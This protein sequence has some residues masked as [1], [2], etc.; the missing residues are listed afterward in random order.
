MM[1]EE[2]RGTGVKGNLT[3]LRERIAEAAR[4][5]GKDPDRIQQVLVT[6]EVPPERIREAYECGERKFGENRVQDFLDK[7]A[8]L[9]RD[10]EW[11]FVGHLQTN[12][13]KALLGKV[14]LI[15]SLDSLHLAREVDRRASG[16]G[17]VADILVQVNTTGEPTKHGVKPSEL[18][19]LMESLGSC[20]S[21][22]VRGLMT[23]GPLTGD[24]RR[25]HDAFRTLSSLREEW[26]R[27]MNADFEY[28][29]MGMS[30]DFE[31]A[32]EEGANLLR[33]GTAVFSEKMR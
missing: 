21:I 4:R 17:L 28:L 12:K 6:K 26:A 3:R 14:R 22:R 25:I 32:I 19:A 7:H 20:R 5:A 18:P 30:G 1:E 13:V 23:I 8:A 29:S 2:G 16:M 31:I 33:I 15:H 24:E 27:R 11:H 9:P 10:I